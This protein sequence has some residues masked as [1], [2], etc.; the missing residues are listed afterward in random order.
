MKTGVAARDPR[1]AFFRAATILCAVVA[2]V[3]LGYEFWR[4]CFVHSVEGGAMDLLM[5]RQEVQHYFRGEPVYSR[6][7]DAV[8][9]PASY[10]MLWPIAGWMKGKGVRWLWGT[11]NVACLVWVARWFRRAGGATGLWERRFLTCFPLATYPVGATIGNGQLGLAILLFLVHALTLLHERERSW[12]RDGTIAA[13]MLLA[14]VKPTFSA[15]FF[16]TVLFVRGGWRPAVLVVVGYVALT[17]VAATYQPTGPV[18]LMRAWFE[19]GVSGATYGATRAEGSIRIPKEPAGPAKG[20]ALDEPSHTAPDRGAPT[21]GAE[22]VG[23]NEKVVEII[24]V[25]LH[26]VLGALGRTDLLTRA[27]VGVLVLLGAWVAI[28]R[29]C[30]LWLLMGVT[31]MVTRFSTYHGWYDD[32][33]LLLPLLALRW[34]SAHGPNGS[35]RRTAEPLF[36]GMALT[37]LA[38]GGVYLL[39][40]PWNNAF[41]L[42]QTAVWGVV[43][44]FLLRAA[45]VE[46]ASRETLAPA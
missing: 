33:L 3:W 40:H 43:L 25:N 32:V 21:R 16:W 36:F 20:P 42:A 13:L 5:R 34:L 11:I 23:A 28:H 41:V 9:P 38:P 39:P 18:V 7:D 19:R 15:C 14:L 35:T 24:N 45:F 26:S 27:S 1:E 6:L 31:A 4:L 2:G 46:K 17:L 10:L 30:S 37:M 12:A 29:R 8:Y 22:N 44:A